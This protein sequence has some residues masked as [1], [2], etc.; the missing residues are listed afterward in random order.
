MKPDFGTRFAGFLWQVSHFLSAGFFGWLALRS[1]IGFQD[2]GGSLAVLIG[3]SSL[4]I[5]MFIL[6]RTKKG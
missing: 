4:S 2:I 6:S 5:A 3:I 1:A